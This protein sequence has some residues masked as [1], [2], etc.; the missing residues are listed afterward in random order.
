MWVGSIVHC[1]TISVRLVL[2]VPHIMSDNCKTVMAVTMRQKMMIGNDK[3]NRLWES[4]HPTYGKLMWRRNYGEKLACSK[5][6]RKFPR[7][8]AKHLQGRIRLYTVLSNGCLHLYSL[9]CCVFVLLS[10][11]IAKVDHLGFHLSRNWSSRTP[12]YPCSVEQIYHDDL[13]LQHNRKC[14]TENKRKMW[15]IPVSFHPRPSIA[16]SRSWLSISHNKKVPGYPK[17]LILPA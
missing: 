13:W 15:N 4:G 7:R 16:P 17:F 10:L 1:Q 12:K 8:Q 5:R 9:V 14:I 3:Y 6:A 2:S 11:L